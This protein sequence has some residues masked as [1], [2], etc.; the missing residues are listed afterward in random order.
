MRWI[1]P[2][3]VCFLGASGTAFA[4][5]I[6]PEQQEAIQDLAYVVAANEE[7]GFMADES[8]IGAY[9]DRHGL[10]LESMAGELAFADRLNAATASIRAIVQR[11][12]TTF[13]ERAWEMFGPDGSKIPGAFRGET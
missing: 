2:V 12:K 6:T 9:L 1:V 8:V 4:Q 11:D 13:C 5:S 3:V 7:C 10:R